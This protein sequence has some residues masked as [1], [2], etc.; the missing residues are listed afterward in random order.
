MKPSASILWGGK[1]RGGCIQRLM[2]RLTPAGKLHLRRRPGKKAKDTRKYFCDICN[3]A[4]AV[5]TDPNIHKP[6]KKHINKAAGVNR[7][8]KAPGYKSWASGNVVARKHYRSICD[9]A[10]ST[11]SKLEIHKA[12]MKH[13]DKA[14]AAESIEL[15]S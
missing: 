2:Q 7:I 10:F 6:T 14:T 4:F 5:S 12:T 15:S 11:S 9:Y 1:L 13:I 3:V 8:V